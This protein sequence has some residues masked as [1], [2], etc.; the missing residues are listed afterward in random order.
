MSKTSALKLSA[1]ALCSLIPAASF[2]TQ[3]TDVVGS[4]SSFN[5]AMGAYALDYLTSGE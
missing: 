2:A 1:I 3:P 4:D 5:T